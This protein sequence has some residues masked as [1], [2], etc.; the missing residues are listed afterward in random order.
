MFKYY[1]ATAFILIHLIVIAQ[2]EKTDSLL[3]DST[4]I[5]I[6][7]PVIPFELS[8]QQGITI[9][10]KFFSSFAISKRYGMGFNR[11]DF[12][13]LPNL[14]SD[15]LRPL[16]LRYKREQELAIYYQIL[17]SLEA[18]TAGYLAY[19]HIKKYGLFK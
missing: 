4:K 15:F 13:S 7:N 14:P 12:E 19:K 6:I 10:L 2:Q 16:S 11:M 1:F 5:I 17:G 18:G 8:S 3:N 9:P